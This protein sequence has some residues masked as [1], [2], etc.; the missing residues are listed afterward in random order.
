MS[1][2][3]IK[4]ISDDYFALRIDA[5]MFIKDLTHEKKI[6]NSGYMLVSQIFVSYFVSCLRHFIFIFAGF[7]YRCLHITHEFIQGFSI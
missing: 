5:N 7:R 4:N 2:I 1:A 3:S 6:R